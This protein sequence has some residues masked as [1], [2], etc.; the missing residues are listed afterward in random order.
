MARVLIAADDTDTSYDIAAAAHQ[1]F[2]VIGAHHRSWLAKLVTGSVGDD[3][4]KRAE[5][6]VLI[7]K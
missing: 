3:V 5:L 7:V 1:L 6:P 4:L 2:G